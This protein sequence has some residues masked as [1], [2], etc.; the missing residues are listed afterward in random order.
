MSAHPL[1]PLFAPRSIALIGAREEPGSVGAVLMANLQSGTYTGKVFPVN[2]RHETVFGAPAHASID[3]VPEPVDLAIL[4]TRPDTLPGILE[5]CAARGVPTAAIISA[6]LTDATRDGA[7]LLQQVGRIA[8]QHGIRLLGPNSMGVIRPSLGL[9]ATFTLAQ[10][11]PG[12]VG[13]VSQSGGLASA[14]LDWAATEGIGFSSVVSLGNQLD[15]D[16]SEALDYLAWDAETESIV[17]YLEGIRNARRFMSALRAAARIKPVIVLKAGRGASGSRAAATHTGA[18]TGADDVFEAA[19]RRAGAVRVGTFVQLVS[20][21]KCLSS[22]YRANGRNIAIV[23]NGGGPGVMAADRAAE[24]GVVVVDLSP[25]TVARLDAA[26]PPAWSRGNPVDLLEDADTARYQHALDACLADPRVDG[27]VV[28][29]TPQGMTDPDAVAAAVVAASHRQSKQLIACWMGDQRV[30]EA[31]K[32]LQAAHLPVFRTPEPAV[33]AFA[34]IASF[35]QNQ[36]LLMQVPGPLWHDEH[37]DIEGA[38]SVIQN[39]LAERRSVLS[40]MESKT[41][42][43]AFHVPIAGTIV[44]D[45]PQR[46]MMIAQQLGF[47]VAMKVQSPEL[48]HKSEIGGVRLNI[49]NSEAVRAAFAD[50]TARVRAARPDARIEGIAIEPM[51]VKPHGREL[52]IGVVKDPVFGPVITCGAGGTGVELIADRA[53]ALPPLNGFLAR[54]LIDRTRVADTLGPWRGWPA[55]DLVAL[56]NLLLRVSE[57]VCELPWLTEMDMNPVIL[58][59]NG[60][61]AVDARI[62]I[63]ALP[64][65]AALERYAHMAICPYPSH[66]TRTWVARDGRE[67]LI[68]AIRPEDAE[69]EQAFVRG[70]SE[71]A[72]YFRFINALHELSDRMLVRFTQIDYDRE[73]ALVAVVDED[74]HDRELGVARYA[75]AT[76]GSSCEFAIVV[77]DEAQGMGLGSRLMGSLMDAARARGLKTMEGFVLA[78]NHRMLK[79]ME[80][81]GFEVEAAPDDPSMR[82]VV[83]KLA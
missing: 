68:R 79:L 34:S 2:P 29:L 73:L 8:R 24:T 71:D 45:T 67:V 21:A 18:M 7:R 70:L 77:G 49:E 63:E 82:R 46:A 78:T 26:L 57:M 10:V 64:P 17:L 65:S 23:T 76:D 83:T 40:E 31:R 12:T 48:T 3:A 43:A 55:T 14:I 11:R 37:P 20:A 28:I 36:R 16:F 6:G 22:R 52:M 32:V 4:A 56:E 38:R 27:V 15:V 61:V 74:G 50:I 60:A 13:L 41:V 53:T 33:E 72:R 9:N 54:N 19:L 62:V 25:E 30:A 35:Y 69:M 75:I 66:L 58:D 47:P 42:L 1:S 51:V 59:E 81:L 39:A 5:R 44:A 80:S